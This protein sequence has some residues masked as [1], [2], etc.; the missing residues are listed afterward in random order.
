MANYKV[1]TKYQGTDGQTYF[2]VDGKPATTSEKAILAELKDECGWPMYLYE[3]HV[4][5]AYGMVVQN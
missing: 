1:C 4:E 5:D 3:G 2:N